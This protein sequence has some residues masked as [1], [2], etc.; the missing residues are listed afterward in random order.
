MLPWLRHFEVRMRAALRFRGGCVSGALRRGR[1]RGAISRAGLSLGMSY[2]DELGIAMS[3]STEEIRRA[4]K[5]MARL[6]HPDWHQDE[7]LRLAAERQMKRL[8]AMMAVLVDPVARRRYNLTLAGSPAALMA[9]G[10]VRSWAVQGSWVWLV[11]VGIAAGLTY[12]FVG[13]GGAGSPARPQTGKGSQAVARATNA[14]DHVARSVEIKPAR[15]IRGTER[16]PEGLAEASAVL[17]PR[18]GESIMGSESTGPFLSSAL[19]AVLPAQVPSGTSKV[20]VEQ[21]EAEVKDQ[22]PP[23]VPAANLP[24]VLI[25]VPPAPDKTAAVVGGLR[26]TWLFVPSQSPERQELLYPPEYIELKIVQKDSLLFGRYRA[27]YRVVDR[28][29][30]PTVSFEFEGRRTQETYGW[31]GADGGRGKVRLRQ[32]APDRLEVS[33]WAN[34]LGDPLSLASGTAVLLREAAQGRE[35]E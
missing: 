10:R 14:S 21:I 25:T 4:Y 23:I 18:E 29:L 6:L 33:W 24:S 22:V 35:E 8:N 28:T 16:Q 19:A 11:T 5:E 9:H 15:A 13:L 26:E 34:K 31:Q 7:G 1:V 30:W 12:Y 32:I 2:Y 20:E 17:E 3:A 27:R